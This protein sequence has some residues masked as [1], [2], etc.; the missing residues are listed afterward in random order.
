MGKIIG[1]SALAFAGLGVAGWLMN[2]L[3]DLIFFSE[4]NGNYYYG[5][6]KMTLLSYLPWLALA[7][8]YAVALFLLFRSEK[9]RTLIMV[10]NSTVVIVLYYLLLFFPID[11]KLPALYIAQAA[12]VPVMLLSIMLGWLF[13]RK[14]KRGHGIW[15]GASGAVVA[16]GKSLLCFGG[17]VGLSYATCALYVG[18]RHINAWTMLFVDYTPMFL[19]VAVVYAC[20]LCGLTA[21]HK[22]RFFIM[23]INAVI[24]AAVWSL[25]LIPGCLPNVLFGISDEYR[26]FFISSCGVT[27]V[28]TVALAFVFKGVEKH[29]GRNETLLTESG[30]TR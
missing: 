14:G 9:R 29:R 21:G 1:K 16:L 10:L 2:L 17:V 6:T 24:L 4:T 27:A 11:V 23:I 30:L 20:L 19:S 7:L 25:V 28:A 8:S 3:A 5:I 12:G 26:G 13:F 22:R 18:S 15:G